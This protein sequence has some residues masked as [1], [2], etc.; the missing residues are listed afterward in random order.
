MSFTTD[1]TYNIGCFIN[2]KTD[3]PVACAKSITVTNPPVVTNPSIFIDKDDSTPGTPD[4]DGHDIQRILS[5]GTA[6]FT[7]FV[8]NNGNEALK[9]VSIEDTLAPDCAR[10][11]AQTVSL[12]SE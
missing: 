12:Y 6:T 3:T 2:D 4:S 11:A 8:R 7:I 1:G 9:T 5:N 10:S